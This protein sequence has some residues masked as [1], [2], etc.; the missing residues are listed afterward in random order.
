MK[1][2]NKK[3]GEIIDL[4]EGI[5]RDDGEHITIKPLAV[6][7]KC[8]IYDSLAELNEE[9]EDYE[10]DELLYVISAEHK[11][12]YQCVLKEEY[13]EIC[14]VAKEL[15][16][17]FETEKECQKFCDKL[18]AWKRLKDKGFRFGHWVIDHEKKCGKVTFKADEIKLTF[19]EAE[20]FYKDITLLFSGGKK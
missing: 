3:N 14:R 12:G 4:Y 8:Y 20:Q 11:S 7:E 13:P 9:W 2:R 16:I 5:I 19:D 10:E 1:I 15:G 6:L 17:G 18:L